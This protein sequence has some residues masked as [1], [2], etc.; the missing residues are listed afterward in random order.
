MLENPSASLLWSAPPL[1][2]VLA[3]GHRIVIDYC[4]YGTRWRKRTAFHV[5][6]SAVPT[7]SSALAAVGEVV[8][9]SQDRSTNF[10]QVMT[11]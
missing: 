11:Q 4:S 2:T 5:F 1:Q 9:L 7:L 8:V 3:E 10:F 6:V